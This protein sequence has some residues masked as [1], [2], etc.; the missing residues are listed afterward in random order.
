MSPSCSL[1]FSCCS[2]RARKPTGIISSSARTASENCEL[3]SQQT[4]NTHIS[5]AECVRGEC[6]QWWGGASLAIGTRRGGFVLSASC[7]VPPRP[8]L[9]SPNLF[10]LWPRLFLAYAERAGNWLRPTKE[11]S[12]S[13][14]PYKRNPAG[15][16][17]PDPL[18]RS[19]TLYYS[20]HFAT[21]TKLTKEE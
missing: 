13:W 17:Y 11:R 10:L 3:S 7:T 15:K 2:C 9:A 19:T 6:L 18:K 8:I 21:Y 12:P 1:L 4:S 5:S 16:Q 20:L 14:T